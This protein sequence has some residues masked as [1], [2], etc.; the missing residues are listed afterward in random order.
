MTLTEPCSLAL[1][2]EQ[3]DALSVDVPAIV[4]NYGS[5]LFRVA[6]SVLRNP[7]E[8]EDAVQDAFVRVLQHRGKLAEIADM[9]VWLVR[10]V[11]NLALDRRRRRRPDQMDDEF[12]ASL[13]A[14]TLPA[15]ER[16]AGARRMGLILREIE[17][18]PPAER[19]T[20]L[21]SA[22][23]ELSTAAIAQVLGRSESAARALLFRAR[24]RLK[25]RLQKGAAV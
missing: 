10:I 11:W 8:A 7:A 3:T 2:H 17:R 25:Q 22:M 21:L 19:E 13:I 6:H 14:H 24:T 16:L 4:A 9:R 20:L 18:L 5:L 12:A 15:D 23:E 1:P